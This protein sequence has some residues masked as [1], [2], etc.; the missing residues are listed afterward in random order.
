MLKRHYGHSSA[1][2][3]AGLWLVNSRVKMGSWS[4]PSPIQYI[5]LYRY[6]YLHI[7]PNMC[8]HI[9]IQYIHIY[10]RILYRKSAHP[11]VDHATTGPTG[12]ITCD[13]THLSW[14]SLHH[15]WSLSQYQPSFFLSH[16]SSHT[17]RSF[18]L[19]T[20]AITITTGMGPW[21]YQLVYTPTQLPTYANI[22]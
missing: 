20:R 5:H 1:R 8:V 7:S 4:D 9:Y 22:P 13:S 15:L 12:G 21:D 6:R 17:V 19:A 2:H 11:H 3:I 18:G 10:P 16:H 14:P